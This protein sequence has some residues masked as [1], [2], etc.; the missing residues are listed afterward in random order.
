MISR[1]LIKRITC[2]CVTFACLAV[3][4]LAARCGVVRSASEETGLVNWL[5]TGNGIEVELVQR[6]PDQTR[7]FFLARGFPP[8]VADEIAT[9]CIFQTIVRNSGTSTHPVSV[10]LAQWRL[11]HADG[12]GGVRLKEAW[13]DSWPVDKISQASRLAFRWATFPT[14]QEFLPGDYNWGMTAFGLAPGGV[15]DLNVVWQEGGQAQSG[16]IRGVECAPDV[17]RLQ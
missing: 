11:L 7:G 8:E 15:F 16:W 1:G 13:M 5:F 4:S 14:Q 10:D 17:D 12:E 3:V 2:A 6:L 9:S